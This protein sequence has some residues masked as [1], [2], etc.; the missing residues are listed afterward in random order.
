VDE[1]VDYEIFLVLTA[2]LLK[3][4]LWVYGLFNENCKGYLVSNDMTG[5]ALL[6]SWLDILLHTG[7]KEAV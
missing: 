3:P 4:H 6:Q 5:C 2:V 1:L 7:S